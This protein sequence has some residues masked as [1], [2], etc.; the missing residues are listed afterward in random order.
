MRARPEKEHPLVWQHQ[1]GR[2]SLVLGATASHIVGLDDEASSRMLDDLLER[3][4]APER[5]YRHE[6]EVGDMVIWDNRGVLHRALPYDA[7]SP[8]DMHRCTLAGDESI[9]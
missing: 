9:A 3:S 5:V 7:D 2:R 4:T 8:R 6:W 1:S